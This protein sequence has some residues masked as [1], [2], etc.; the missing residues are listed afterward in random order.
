MHVFINYKQGADPDHELAGKIEERLR[1]DGHGVFRDETGLV[2][3]EKWTERLYS[4]IKSCDTLVAIVSNQS[5]VSKWCLTEIDYA[6]ANKKRVLPVVVAKIDDALDFQAFQPRFKLTQ[7]Y[8]LSGDETKDIN[9]ISETLVEPK[10]KSY[11]HLVNSLCEKHGIADPSELISSL[12][13]T[14]AMLHT[15]SVVAN[16]RYTDG[17]Y[18]DTRSIADTV[19]KFTATQGDI[20]K[21]NSQNA[22]AT[23]R[24]A[25]SKSLSWKAQRDLCLAEILS[26]ALPFWNDHAVNQRDA[27][28]AHAAATKTKP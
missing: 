3:A 4:E 2:P 10:N 28:Q 25:V 26:E 11:E 5:L 17:I 20:N 27:I 16:Q 19:A 6:F 22:M 13:D 1:S 12:L 23:N 24:N 8:T 18:N 21:S 15:M 9:A 14:L 7:Y